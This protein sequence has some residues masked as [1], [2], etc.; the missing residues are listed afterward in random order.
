MMLNVKTIFCLVLLCVAGNSFAASNDKQST[1]KLTAK[2]GVM[3]K[4]PWQALVTRNGVA[5]VFVVQDNQARFRMVRLG[6]QV[7]NSVYILAGLFGNET[8]LLGNVSALF[9]GMPL[10]IN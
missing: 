3:I 4:I 8:L 9:D 5:G 6:K 1:F 7:K 10:N 2:K